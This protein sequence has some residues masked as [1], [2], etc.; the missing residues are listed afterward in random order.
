MTGSYHQCIPHYADIFVSLVALTK[1]YTCMVDDCEQ[2]FQKLKE[3]LCF[4]HIMIHPDPTPPSILHTDASDHAVG[5]ILTQKKDGIDR[6]AQY[7]SKKLSIEECKRE[8]APILKEAYAIIHALK[9]LL[10]IFT[11]SSV[12]HLHWPCPLTVTLLRVRWKTPCSSAG[13][14]KSLSLI[15]PF[16]TGKRNIISSHFVFGHI[17]LVMQNNT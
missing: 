6:P 15:A 14:C 2:A 3:E 17:G 9:K 7:V 11:R 12:H 16:N 10:A 1:K 13:E 5:A 8:W 4:V